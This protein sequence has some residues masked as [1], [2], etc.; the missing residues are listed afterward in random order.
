MKLCVESK[1]IVKDYTEEDVVQLWQPHY[2]DLTP[3]KKYI[4]IDLVL[5][6]MN[7]VQ[8]IYYQEEKNYEDDLLFEQ[9]YAFSMRVPEL[10]TLFLFGTKTD[11][12]PDGQC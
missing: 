5:L 2:D 12:E 1:M 4:N 3:M 11:E 10:Q 8:N 9:S 7:T 6:I